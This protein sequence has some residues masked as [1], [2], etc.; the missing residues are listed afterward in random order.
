MKFSTEGINDRF[1]LRI[2]VDGFADYQEEENL[3]AGDVRNI[4]ML[5]SKGLAFEVVAVRHRR[6]AYD[7]VMLRVFF[8]DGRVE[9]VAAQ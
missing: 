2:D 9:N 4:T 5:E 8:K 6:F 1:Y 3:I 7:F